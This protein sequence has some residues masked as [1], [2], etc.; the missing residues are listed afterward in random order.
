MRHLDVICE[1][2]LDRM[3]LHEDIERNTLTVM[4]E[5]PGVKKEDVDIQVEDGRLTVTAENKL[6]SE[7]AES[8][9]AVR[10]MRY[11]HFLRSIILPHGIEVRFPFALPSQI[12]YLAT[13]LTLTMDGQA[14]D[15]TASMSDGILRLTLHRSI[16]SQTEEMQRVPDT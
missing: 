2:R 12:T 10:E 4:L 16:R 1:F 6:P 9:Y 15:M 7:F 13:Y 14:N 8:G 5:L 3:D 11:G